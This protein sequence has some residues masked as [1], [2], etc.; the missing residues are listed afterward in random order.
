MVS[1]K[2]PKNVTYFVKNNM[3]KNN[4]GWVIPTNTRQEQEVIESH[5]KQ[6]PRI[7]WLEHYRNVEVPF[8]RMCESLTDLDKLT[9]FSLPVGIANRWIEYIIRKE[10][11]RRPSS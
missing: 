7:D 11:S 10:E 3:E 5:L 1:M 6:L 8:A 4:M 2:C 9:V